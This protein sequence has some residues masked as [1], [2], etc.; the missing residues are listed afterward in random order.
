MTE[1]GPGL[2][3]DR[4]LR[5]MREQ[6]GDSAQAAAMSRAAAEQMQEA[7]S[8]ELD[9]LREEHAA[10]IA[11]L[12]QQ[13]ADAESAVVVAQ[14]PAGDQ[15]GGAAPPSAEKPPAGRR[16]PARVRPGR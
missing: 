13:L 10:E 16:Q 2:D 5:H 3:A 11:Q 12:R 6:V 1:A 14:Q 7:C 9:R 15:P 4:V 8:T